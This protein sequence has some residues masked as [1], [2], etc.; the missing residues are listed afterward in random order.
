MCLLYQPLSL[1]LM[2]VYSSLTIQ[3]EAVISEVSTVQVLRLRTNPLQVHKVKYL[4]PPTNGTY[5]GHT[6]F[7]NGQALYL[8]TKVFAFAEPR[9]NID[10]G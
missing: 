6:G 5:H 1:N 2:W 7:H 3:S 10:C 9:H 4:P 8:N